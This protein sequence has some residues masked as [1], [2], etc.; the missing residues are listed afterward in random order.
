MG[1]HCDCLLHIITR[2]DERVVVSGVLER[3]G[4]KTVTVAA[5]VLLVIAVAS[6]LSTVFLAS[7]LHVQKHS[8]AQHY[9]AN[10][11]QRIF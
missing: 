6:L 2:R 11:H 5:I 7:L 3:F 8:F 10:A 1:L 4:L 9:K